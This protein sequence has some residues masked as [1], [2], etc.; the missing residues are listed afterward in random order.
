M[1]A[2]SEGI[3]ELEPFVQN[4]RNQKRFKADLE[5]IIDELKEVCTKGEGSLALGK[6]RTLRDRVNTLKDIFSR[7]K[8]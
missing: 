2:I 4:P 5:E 8:G 1:E 3:K 6:M 7:E